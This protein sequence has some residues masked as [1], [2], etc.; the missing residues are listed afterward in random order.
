[1]GVRGSCIGHF[2]A[3]GDDVDSPFQTFHEMGEAVFHE[4]EQGD[5]S[6][7][8][9]AVIEYFIRVIADDDV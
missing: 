8:R 1:M 6:D 7:I 4:A 3:G 9:I 5:D 2:F